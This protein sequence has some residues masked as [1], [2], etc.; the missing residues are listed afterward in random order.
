MYTLLCLYLPFL[1]VESLAL[2]K[3]SYTSC[4]LSIY[5]SY[6][7]IS[8]VTPTGFVILTVCFLAISKFY[9]SLSFNLR[10]SSIYFI[11]FSISLMRI[12]LS[13]KNSFISSICIFK[14]SPSSLNFFNYYESFIFLWSSLW[15]LLVYSLM[16]A[17]SSFILDDFSVNYLCKSNFNS[18]RW[19]FW[20]RTKEL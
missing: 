9:I 6:S 3:P 14:P 8:Y 13:S 11:S 19:L 17:S 10:F 12:S 16:R 18:F 20:E 4:D 1:W 5:D 15:Y 2:L 7:N